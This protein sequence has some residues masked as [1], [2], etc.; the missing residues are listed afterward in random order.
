VREVFLVGVGATAFG[1]SGRTRETLARAAAAA[2]LADARLRRGIA[3]PWMNGATALHDGWRA[4]ASGEHDVVLCVAAETRAGHE[5]SDGSLAL[6]ARLARS[7]MRASGATVE[8]LAKVVAKNRAQGAANPRATLAERV[9]AEAVL[10]SDLLAWPLR[11]LM[12]APR[13]DGAAAVVLA[14][15]GRRSGPR[16][17]RVRASV[18]VE[19]GADGTDVSVPAAR[20]AMLGFEA[21]GAGPEDV[22]CAEVCDTTAADELRAYEALQF[23]PEGHGPELVES[24]FTA[25]GGVLPVNTSGGMLSQGDAG[26][27]SLLAQLCELV[28]QLRGEAGR[29]QVAGARVGVALG[30]TGGRNGRGGVS[31]TVLSS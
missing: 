4:V 8:H 10:H 25:L 24:G 30:R 22:D 2:A 23:V 26:G 11:R 19:C 12:V 3:P 18:V 5:L 27:A 6:R 28:W 29:R 13:T 1:R 17:P 7:Y 16:A 15:R 14:A 9:D 21:A 31:L 20:A